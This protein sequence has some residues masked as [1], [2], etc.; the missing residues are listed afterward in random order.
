MKINKGRLRFQIAQ[1]IDHWVGLPLCGLVGIWC[2]VAALLPF[3]KKT[4]L[5]KT[6]RSILIVKWYGLGS[7]ILMRDLIYSLRRKYQDAKI[8][9]LT[10]EGNRGLIQYLSLADELVTVRKSSAVAFLVDTLRAL[11]YLPFKKIDIAIDLEFYSKYS[12][13]MTYLSGAPVRV[14][15]YLSAFWR[16]ALFTHCVYFNYF[17]HILGIYAMVGKS[18]GVAVEET[19]AAPLHVTETDLQETKKV[20]QKMGFNGVNKLIGINVNAGEMAF[21]RRWPKEYFIQVIEALSL[22]QNHS[23]VLIGA[24]EDKEY[25]DS[26]YDALGEKTKNNVINTAGI[27]NLAQFITLVS[28]FSFIITNDSG[29]LHLAV[30]L[31]IPTISIWGPGTPLLYGARDRVKHKEFYSEVDC[32][33]CMYIYRTPAGIFCNN[34]AFCLKRV[35]PEEVIEYAL[36]LAGRG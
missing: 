34:E 17:K 5:P 15:F 24:L 25:T 16:R 18:I 22:V 21:C 3:Q 23:V 10:F 8:I 20:L 13:L 36:R 27:F 28:N 9:F 33:P 2:T 31:G 30:M 35:K 1:G 26:I 32:S 6:P 11:C 4:R 12:T 29:P 14:G 7:I 19:P